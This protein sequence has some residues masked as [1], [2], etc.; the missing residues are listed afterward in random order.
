[1]Q[2]NIMVMKLHPT[3][4]TGNFFASMAWLLAMT[5]V[6]QVTGDYRSAASGN[7]TVA[8]TWERFDGNSFVAAPT[9]PV[10]TDGVITIRTGHTVNVNIPTTADQVVVEAGATL[11][12]PSILNLS[13]GAGPDLVVN[14]TLQLNAGTFQGS[15][16]AQVNAGGNFTWTQGTI[17]SGVVLDLLAGSTATM[18]GTAGKANNGT[19]NNAGTFTMAGGDILSGG[20]PAAFNNL[21]GGV[22]N[23]NGWTTNTGTWSQFTNNQGTIN[24]NNG[25]TLFTFLRQLVNS[26]TINVAEGELRIFNS[27]TSENTG[28]I[29][30]TPPGSVLRLNGNMDLNSG[31]VITGLDELFIEGGICTVNSANSIPSLPLITIPN[32]NGALDCIAP[33][34][35][36]SLVMVNGTLR[37][38]GGLTVINGFNWTG[39]VINSTGVL[40]L[41]AT[42]TTVLAQGGNALINSGI[43]NNAGTFLMQAGSLLQTTTPCR[44]NNLPG[45]VLEL[46]G[47]ANPTGS[48]VQNVFNQG[49]VNKHNGDVQFTFVFPFTNEPTGVLNANTGHVA[50]AP[51]FS[52]PVQTGVF[53][54]AN[55]A[56]LSASASGIPYAGPEFN[57][58]GTVN[59][60]L[61]FE[62]SSA[63]QLN[64]N[65]TITSLTINN[66]AGVDLG[67]EQTVTSTLTMTNG[68]LRLGDNDLFVE[69]NAAGAVAGGN[70]SS[71]V[72]N[73]GT[74]SLHRQVNGNNYLFPLGT[75][76]YTPL[77]MS[78][79][80][81]P[82]DRFSVRVQDGVSTE[83]S[84]PGVAAGTSISSDIVDRTWVVSE[85]VPGGNTASITLQWNAADELPG[86]VRTTCA[87]AHY[88]NPDWVPGAFGAAIGNGPFTRTITGLG[89]FRE[90]CVT[91]ADATLNDI[92]TG[93]TEGAESGLHV[94]PVPANDILYIDLPEG[95]DTQ[96]LMLLDAGGRELMSRSM[97]GGGRRSISVSDLPSGLHL[98]VLVDGDGRW[99]RKRISIA[100]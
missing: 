72:V 54:V 48:W 99:H 25:P 12:I 67:G 45:G 86:F 57:N 43:I 87:V 15:G 8:S 27:N 98:L 91:D 96:T 37:G 31:G 83:Y 55:G 59:A 11:S 88:S 90:L 79:T 28:T 17:G 32:S 69:N 70:A 97:N 6:A 82:Q 60:T 77:T 24:K 29:A 52:L 36:D 58:N 34:T 42:C 80:N 5:S 22:V 62:G 61:K 81:G 51:S 49:T 78:L 38:G 21:P 41:P 73:N 35:T 1:M 93:M 94:H 74:G 46:N 63:Q 30:F 3:P 33:L 14:G 23:L 53:N 2:P 56:S 20:S 16:L 19:I 75:S 50:L 85:E 10:E 71:W 13:D 9:A 100:H 65:G 64:G 84:A 89:D 26:G 18:S 68:Q 92:G 95:N 76:S 7:W 47:W 39:G 4:F 44:F 66:A 40:N